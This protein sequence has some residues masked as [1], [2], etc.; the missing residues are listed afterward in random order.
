MSKLPQESLDRQRPNN[1]NAPNSRTQEHSMKCAASKEAI[2][3]AH[4]VALPLLLI[5]ASSAVYADDAPKKPWQGDVEAG[6]IS[7]EGNTTSKSIKTGLKL[8]YEEAAWRH[9]GAFESLNAR[10]NGQDTAEKYFLEAKSGYTFSQSNY[11]FVYANYT[12]DRFTEFD[13]QTS[14]SAGYGRVI[15]DSPVQRW[16]AEI[17]PGHRVTRDKDGHITQE[18]IAHVATNYLWNISSTSRFEQN[19]LVEAGSSNTVTRSKSSLVA[20]LNSSFSMKLSYTLTY[21]KEIPDALQ[22]NDTTGETTPAKTY[23]A[24]KETSVSLLYAF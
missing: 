17:G 23:H 14:V 20:Q 11:A 10:Q 24:D 4:V 16:D 13:F 6:M 15:I 9:T 22:T 12:D 18:A 5:I 8:T 19:V 7:T 3:H 21:N 1:D 2:K